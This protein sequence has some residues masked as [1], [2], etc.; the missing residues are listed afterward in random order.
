MANCITDKGIESLQQTQMCLL[1][2]SLKLDGLYF[3]IFKTLKLEIPKVC[4]IGLEGLSRRYRIK[5]GGDRLSVHFAVTFWTAEE[6][7]SA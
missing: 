2:K 4:D 6:L 1:L 5:E 7:I 3:L